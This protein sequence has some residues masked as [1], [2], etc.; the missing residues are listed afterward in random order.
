V[1]R[2]LIWSRNR[3]FVDGRSDFYGNDFEDKYHDILH[4]KYGWEKTLATFRV[5]TIL[6]PLDAPLTGAL[7]ESSRWRLVYDD[8]KALAS[9]PTNGTRA[10]RFPPPP[11]AEQAVI[12]RSRKRRRVIDRARNSRPRAKKGAYEHDVFAQLL[13]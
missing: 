5:D 11:A 10:N 3:V 2:L 12:A 4:V 13:E 1:G 9:G 7:K 6:M 8:G